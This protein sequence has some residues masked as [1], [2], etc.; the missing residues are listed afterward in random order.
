MNDCSRQNPGYRLYLKIKENQLMNKYLK[1]LLVSTVIFIA[2]CGGSDAD[3]GDQHIFSWNEVTG[4]LGYNLYCGTASGSYVS[5][6]IISGGSVVTYPVTSAGLP[7]GDN[8]CALT[9]FNFVGE[10]GFSNEISFPVD[11]GD[12]AMVAPGIPG[13]FAIN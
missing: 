8:F 9:S 5:N 4:A 7:D 12:L 11:G 13:N 3:H 1:I 2:A 6:I 10:S